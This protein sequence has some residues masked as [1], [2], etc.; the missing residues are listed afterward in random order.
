MFPKEEKVFVHSGCNKYR[1]SLETVSVIP[2]FL[3]QN[4]KRRVILLEL[5]QSQIKCVVAAWMNVQLI[6]QLS[7]S[8]D[9]TH[10]LIWC[11]FSVEI[12]QS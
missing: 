4:L 9:V 3:I 1:F 7:P 8:L 5:I 12:P 11:L 10:R 2:S 6:Q